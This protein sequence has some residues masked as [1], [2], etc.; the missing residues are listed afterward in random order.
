MNVYDFDKTIYDGDCTLDFYKYCL[1]RKPSL[2]KYTPSQI[3]AFFKYITKSIRK[4]QFKETVYKMLV[5]VD[6]LS[7]W[8]NDFWDKHEH[9]IKEFYLKQQKHDDLVISASPEFLIIPICKR[10][11]IQAMA[12]L[13]DTK[14]GLHIDKVNCHGQRKVERFKEVFKDAEVDEFYSD[15]FT[16]EPC[17]LLAKKAYFVIK[18]KLLLWEDAK[19]RS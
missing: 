13:I 15:S 18:D 3:I 14:T 11:N 5:S 17:A 7:G 10:L 2:I 16:D 9:K 1:T 4:E 8:V 12:S 19:K 6:D